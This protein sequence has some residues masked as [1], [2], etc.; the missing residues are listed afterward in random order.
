MV[1]TSNQWPALDR[2]RAIDDPRERLEYALDELYAYYERTEPML[3][4]V[5]R[6]AELVA[7]VRDAVVP[8]R[9]NLED[10]AQVLVVGRAVRGRRRQLLSA[11]LR[12]ALAC[13]TWRSLASNGGL[14]SR[15]PG[16]RRRHEAYDVTA[17]QTA[18]SPTATASQG[19]A[20]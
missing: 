2:W 4:N 18:P 12:H 9:A 8:L 14:E 3:G 16:G 20:G 5:L 1:S 7:V 17:T 6:D 10:A 13:S 11:A 19:L 15:R